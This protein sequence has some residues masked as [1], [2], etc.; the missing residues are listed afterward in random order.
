MP[1]DRGCLFSKDGQFKNRSDGQPVD[2]STWQF[3]ASLK[4]SEGEEVLTMSTRGGH[5]TVFDGPNGWLR[6]ALTEA[7]TTALEAGPVSFTI[8]RTDGGRRRFGRA[9]VTVRDP[10]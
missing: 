4:D 9:T 2:V 1:I 3:E 5:F 6:I 7:E 8:Y 10:E